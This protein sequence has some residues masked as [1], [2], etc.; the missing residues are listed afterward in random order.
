MHMAPVDDK[1]ALRLTV[2][3]DAR[4][5]VKKIVAHLLQDPDEDVYRI[6]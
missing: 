3:E 6:L 1:L 4:S 5:Q 2:R